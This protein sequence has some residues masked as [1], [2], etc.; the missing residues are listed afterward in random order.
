MIDIGSY[1]LLEVKTKSPIGFYLTDGHDDV[2]LP[3]KYVPDNANEGDE[4]KV[5]VYLD[6]ENRPVATTLQP[7]ASV[8]DFAF[9]TVKDVN[10]FGA[11][12]DWGIA[13]DIFVSYS[14]QRTPMTIGEEYLV[15]L[16]IDDVSGRI[17]A[18]TRWIK[19]IEKDTSEFQE[20]DE[21]ELL[22]AE[23]TDLGF[24]AIV[25]NRFEGLIYANEVFGEL[26]PGDR[27]RGY[28]KFI[29]DDGKIDL[30][31]QPQGYS[32]IE[33]SKD[34]L[35][36]QLQANKGSLPLGDKSEPEEIYSLLKM[37][38]KAF[39]RAAGGLFKERLITIS[40]N[41]IKLLDRKAE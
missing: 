33:E 19:Y 7:F 20:G 32:H 16:F 35:L 26:N 37:S 40:D 28:V 34:I 25:D 38:K 3:K 39:K 23:R 4:I 5:F 36:R 14:E 21:V 6:N 9:L 18:T 30:R 24:K 10:E 15:Y 17:A 29:R 8:G 1:N 27:K 22:I 13:K 41:E 31:L 2:L 11:F 12:L